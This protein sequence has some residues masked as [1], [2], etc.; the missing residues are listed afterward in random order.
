MRS[1]TAPHFGECY[2][3]VMK[4]EFLL[5]F[6]V[7]AVLASGCGGSG[8]GG[9]QSVATEGDAVVVGTN[10]RNGAPIYTLTTAGNGDTLL[11]WPEGAGDTVTLTVR[12][13]DA[14]LDAY[15][16]DLVLE[17][18]TTQML[19]PVRACGRDDGSFSVAWSDIT[20]VE[21]MPD[22]V[23][24]ETGNVAAINVS[25][26]GA[27][28]GVFQVNPNDLGGQFSSDAACLDNGNVVVA[29]AQLCEGVEKD[30][31]ASVWFVPEE[32]ASEPANGAYLRVIKYSGDPVAP[33]QDVYAANPP[34]T[35][36]WLAPLPDNKM[37][38]VSGTLI[39]VR[40]S[41]GKVIRQTSVADGPTSDGALDCPSGKDCLAAFSNDAVGVHALLF[42]PTTLSATVDIEIEPSV[43]ESA[44]VLVA[45]RGATAAC[46]GR[47]RCLVV[48]QR[49]RETTYDDYIDLETLGI[50]GRIVNARNGKLGPVALLIDT[51]RAIDTRLR[52]V[53]NDTG[54]FVLA[55]DPDDSVALQQIVVD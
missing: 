47:S 21:N 24:L 43:Q 9:S 30:G 19:A 53:S 6:F 7:S 49:Q 26:T 32:C 3:A 23:T 14:N 33:V 13:F 50:Y 48:W 42:D 36:V 55:Y 31:D 35:R 41:K 52:V 2:G 16:D 45:P 20:P 38:L 54:R 28:S 22:G 37:A 18:P 10:F 51:D 34:A 4:R 17:G 11:V 1:L 5:V 15:A 25:K 8:G 40:D 29:W 12:R 44:N 27:L 46:D 39:Q